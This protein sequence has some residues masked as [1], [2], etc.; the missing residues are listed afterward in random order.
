MPLTEGTILG[1]YEV[2]AILGAGGMGEVYRARDLRLNRE[3]AIKVLPEFYSRDPERLRR[4]E[5]EARAAAAL[6]HPNILAVYQLGSTDGVIYIVSEL[7]EGESLRERLQR[8]PLPLQKAVDLGVQIAR[9]LAA[10]HKKGIVHRDVKPENLFITRDGHAKILDFGLARMETPIFER[11]TIHP[12]KHT[13][14]GVQMGTVGYMSPEQVRG[15]T[16]DERSDI[17]SFCIVLCEMLTGTP[18]FEKPTSVEIMTAILNEHPA[19]HLSA[20]IPLG[21]QRVLERGMEKHPEQRFQS[22]S[23]LAFA[24]ESLSDG[25]MMAMSGI[26]AA[27]ARKKRSGRLAAIVAGILTAAAL[28]AGAISLLTQ[29]SGPPQAENYVQLTH[30]GLQ[31]TLIGTDGARLYL[32]LTTSAVNDLAVLDIADREESRLALAANDMEPVNLAPD[33]SAFLVVEGRGVPFRGAFWSVPVLG[34]SP[35]KLADAVGTTGTW[36]PDGKWLAYADGGD[37]YLAQADGTNPRKIRAGSLQIDGITWTPDGKLLRLSESQGFG[38]AIGAHSLWEMAPD[39]SGLHQVLAGWHN[40]PDECCG[41]WTPDGKFFL[42]ASGGQIWALGREGRPFHQHLSPTQLTESPMTLSSPVVSRDG[43]KLFAVGAT[44]RGELTEYDPRTGQFASYLGGISGE[45]VAFSRDGQWVAWVT[46]PEGELWRSRIDGSDR[47]Q[48][49][50]PP[51]HPALPRWSPDGKNLVYFVFPQ[52]AT[53][54]ARIF[55]IAAS[56][57]S[58][59]ALMPNVALHQQ[60][61]NWSPDGTRIVFSGDQN[62]AAHDTATPTIHILDLATHQIADVPGSNGMF[63]PRWSPDGKSLVALNADSR[64]LRQFS[65]A[66]RAWTK[67]ADGNFGWVN[68]SS[69]G[70]YVYSLDFTGDGSVVRV[71]LADGHVETVA[72]LKGFVTTGQFGGALSLTPGDA[73]LLLR[74]RGTQDVYA[75][76]FREK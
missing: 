51:E 2:L 25:S 36:S 27:A 56:G 69:D 3:V 47:L 15:E 41:T 34:G 67:V 38:A 59:K 48:L 58:P 65:F 17:F 8:G 39:G 33:G 63:S 7:L 24:L 44:F 60:D 54:P 73:P 20:N 26:R 12:A 14:P 43:K 30:D 10:A 1:D 9:G 70:K 46:Y 37:L 61:P 53:R 71:R 49:T 45:Y 42:F 5:Q 32:S 75:L 74:D 18:T 50:S 19:S 66:T 6:N 68:Y 72:S 13:L 16:A 62:D 31:K 23:D 57:G 64:T 35:R 55:E 4:F 76:D 52:S 22:A 29:G 11:E 40:P 28:A 21:L